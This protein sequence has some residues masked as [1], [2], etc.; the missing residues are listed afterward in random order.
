MLCVA[1]STTHALAHKSHVAALYD[2]GLAFSDID[3]VG[4]SF[5]F[6]VHWLPQD[7]YLTFG[8][9]ILCKPYHNND[10][11]RSMVPHINALPTFHTLTLHQHSVDDDG[12]KHLD[13]MSS[14]KN[15]SLSGGAFSDRGLLSLHTFHGLKSL[16]LHNT[17]VT[18]EGVADL[19]LALPNCQISVNYSVATANPDASAPFSPT[20]DITSGKGHPR[21]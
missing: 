5:L 17:S 15:L 19:R 1:Q 18:T 11:L 8:E 20:G 2:A 6:D 10:A 14:L 9:V 13:A 7:Y 4:P 21:G 16:S 12:V 3:S